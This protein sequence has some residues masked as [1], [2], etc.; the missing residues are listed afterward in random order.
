MRTE[1]RPAESSRRSGRGLGRI[2]VVLRSPGLPSG[3]PA[4]LAAA[5]ALMIPA[6]P[7]RGVEAPRERTAS[8]EPAAVSLLAELRPFPLDLPAGRAL[9]MD[10][11]LGLE[12]RS[13]GAFRCAVHL[14]LAVWIAL[15]EPRPGRADA[16]FGDPSAEVGAVFS[17]AGRFRSLGA[18]YSAPLGVTV[19]DPDR[20]LRPVPGAGYHR[21]TVSA[22]WGAVRDPV[23]LACGFFWSASFPRSEDPAPVWKPADIGLSFTLVE[24]LNDGVGVLFGISPRL[25]APTLGPG[26]AGEAGCTWDL[27]ARFEVHLRAGRL[28]LRAGTSRSLADPRAPYSPVAGV[29]YEFRI[30]P[31]GGGG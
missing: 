30:G 20:P 1:S 13:A 2:Q 29:E 3:L 21:V 8:R 5:A 31:A 14:P 10:L 19:P 22:G 6:G 16:A 17:R 23:A 9:G 28:F 15:G 7:A 26:A 24:V 25:R 4:V 27:E 18:G 11:D 12:Y